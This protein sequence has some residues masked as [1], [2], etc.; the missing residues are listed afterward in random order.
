MPKKLILKDFELEEISGVDRPAQ[1]P[2]LMSIIKRKEKEPD[3]SAEELKKLQKQ[4]SDL[5]GALELAKSMA[6]L[7]DTEKQFAQGMD[8]KEQKSFAGMSSDDRK[9]RMDMAKFAEETLE[10][11]GTL[12]NKAAIGADMFE[13]LKSQQAQIQKQE[14]ETKMARD[15]AIQAT[16]VK[17]ASDD[18]SHVP[19]TADQIG[20]LL[21]ETADISKAS[22]DTLEAVLIALEKS[23]ASA[24]VPKG[25]AGG[26]DEGESAIEKLDTLAKA[27]SEKNSVDYATAYS[28]VIE[29]NT[30][31]YAETLN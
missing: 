25:H 24:F 22:K 29:K 18:Y 31:L 17:R 16:F 28:A 21:R 11:N 1:A 15:L 19:G 23:N 5:T 27:Y 3:M 4:V 6:S 2:A 10:I 14:A 12:I 30:D 9:A 20:T 7:S 26:N 8:E 13:V